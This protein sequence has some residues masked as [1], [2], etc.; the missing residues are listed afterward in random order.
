[1]RSLYESL[2][3]DDD[4]VLQRA[5][6]RAL[7]HRVDKMLKSKTPD[8]E[9][10]K[11]LESKV[12]IYRVNDNKDLRNLISDY[13]KLVGNDCS[14]NWIDVSNVEYM[15][16]TFLRSEFNGDISKW[17]VSKVESMRGTF[18]KSKFN[19]DISKWNV[20]KVEDM[21][22][23]F[24]YSE[25]NGDISKWNVSK[26]RD[27]SYMFSISKFNGDISKWNVSKVKQVDSIFRNCPIKEEY[28]PKFK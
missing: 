11:L 5:D 13:T 17:D 21:S 16:Y 26:V 9:L 10:I 15:G 12:A 4:V 24:Y 18:E 1:M 20:S 6:N 14:L 7:M 8:P 28:K 23:M 19:G 2:M 27:M 25:F 3:D 22:G